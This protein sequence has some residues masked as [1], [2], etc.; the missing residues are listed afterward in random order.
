MTEDL[1]SSIE[2]YAAHGCPLDDCFYGS[3]GGTYGSA[4]GCGGCCDCRGGCRAQQEA[5]RELAGE[6]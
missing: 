2:D 1:V 4:L 6:Q 3:C 5:I